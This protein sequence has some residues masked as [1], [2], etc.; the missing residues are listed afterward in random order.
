MSLSVVASPGPSATIGIGAGSLLTNWLLKG[1]VS[2]RYV[3]IASIM[4]TVFLLDLYFAAGAAHAALAA[5]DGAEVELGLTDANSSCLVRAP[6]STA[7]RYVVM[8]M[9]L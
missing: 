7:Q 5:I 9:R 4:M 6:G 1:E 2:P 8:P 3:P